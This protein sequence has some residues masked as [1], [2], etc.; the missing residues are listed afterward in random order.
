MPEFH[1][2]LIANRGEIALR[3][4]RTARALGY[5]TVAVYSEIDRGA[6]HVAFAD[7]AVPI[8]P[9]PASESYL[10]TE[11]I[12][13]AA[14]HS[15]A[16]AIHPGYGFL[17]ENAAFAQACADAGLV[18][19][20]PP[21]DAIRLMGNK[22]A[23]K[24]RMRA[25]GVPC[26]PGYDGEDQDDTVVAEQAA[27]IGLP[28]MI[29]AAAGGG[30]KGMRLVTDLSRLADALRGA[31]TEAEKAFGSGE[32]ILEKAVIE[33]RHIE[34]QVFADSHG[35]VI[36]LGERDCSIQR[37]HQKVIE[38]APGP[39]LAPELRA[40]LGAAAV[41][42]AAAIGYVGAGTIEFLL[43]P[44]AKFFFLEMNTRLQVEHA[45]TEMITGLDLVEW[46]LRVA[47]G[48]PLPLRQ[49]EVTIRGHA[50]EARLYAEDEDFL[51]QAGNVLAFSAPDGI[52]MDHALAAG[53]TVS[54]H[55]DPML[56]K[57][58]AHGASRA[59][60]RRKLIT[61]LQD[62]VVLGVVTN[63]RFLIDC[64]TSQVFAQGGATTSFLD[65][66]APRRAVRR[67]SAAMTALAAVLIER[68]AQVP[69]G[70]ALS[71]WRN[72]GA[73]SSRLMLK[74]GDDRIAVEIERLPD[75]SSRVAVAN[76]RHDVA[77]LGAA[78]HRVRFRQDGLEQTAHF[79]WDR[80]VLHLTLDGVTAT[81]QDVLL[82]RLDA[83]AGQSPAAAVAPMT[84][85][86]AAVRV[87]PG[88]AVTKGQCLLILEA[89][90]MEHEILAPR[91][92]VVAAVLVRP[93]EQVTTRKVLVELAEQ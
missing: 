67:P 66:H 34:V 32:L 52:R 28:V 68:H 25:A 12:I 57:L 88:E 4:A 36:H 33:P 91:A 40:A 2:V 45:V 46:Q 6:P 38:E 29:K 37:R 18:F 56:G 61:A 59:E 22:A 27:A 8:G 15:G 69:V 47:A 81:F 89:M 86:I 14:R 78:R 23:A 41:K 92:G 53:V 75:G 39:G 50:I 54:A 21:S 26:I 80:D 51:P 31:R 55:Y 93:G 58:I 73:A 79:A 85:T 84:G 71:H 63:R 65:R 42:A 17:S 70:D 5:R 74:A 24:R 11:K 16:D 48:E 87:T 7:Q 44:D 90:K 72:A 19:I 9:A 64:L 1:K 3:V 10:A 62:L 77:I 49:E 43:G 82:A 83:A 20:G 13:A 35:E 60:A 30:G 76:A